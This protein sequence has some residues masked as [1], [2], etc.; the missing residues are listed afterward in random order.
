MT[1][2]IADE[3]PGADESGPIVVGIDDG[4]SS[5]VALAWAADTAERWGVPLVLASTYGPRPAEQYDDDLTLR[6]TAAAVEERLAAVRAAVLKSHPGVVVQVRAVV[7]DPGSA[8]VREAS[9]AALVV[10]GSH[11]RGATG[12]LV[13]GSV[14]HAVVTRS[15]TPVAVVRQP[16][17]DPTL[18]VVVGVELPAAEEAIEFAAKEARLRTATLVVLHA[19]HLSGPYSYAEIGPDSGALAEIQ[20]SD[21]LALARLVDDVRKRHPGLTV[22]GQVVAGS[23]AAVLADAA[24]RAQLLVVGTH[25]RG[26]MGRLVLGSV[27]TNVLHDVP[28]PVVVVPGRGRG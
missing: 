2:P 5:D 1:E 10:V 12:R 26:A 11:G 28:S 13:L 25:G 21:E 22:E 7:G 15:R 24:G 8:L 23:P 20:R 27:S 17:G 14:S 3:V 18:P 19:W 4:S 16:V 6:R 9:T